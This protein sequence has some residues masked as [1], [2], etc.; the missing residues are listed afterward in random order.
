MRVADQTKIIERQFQ[1]EQAQVEEKHAAEIKELK[2]LLQSWKVEAKTANQILDARIGELEANIQRLVG[3]R[4]AA[5]N[6]EA[7]TH[8]YLEKLSSQAKKT[9]TS[10]EKKLKG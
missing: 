6:R 8:Q 1:V 9:K 2:E 5:L 7:A 3:E 10:L 4:D